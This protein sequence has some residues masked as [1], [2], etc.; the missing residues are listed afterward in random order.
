M[1]NID[2]QEAR[3]YLFGR[4][5]PERQ[6]ELDALRETHA[7]LREEF[8]ALEE[9]LCDQY[10]A[11][12]LP[13]AEKQYF[14]THFLTTASGK[15]KL[16]FAELFEQ[17]RDHL[18]ERPSAVSRAPAPNSPPLPASSPLFATFNRNPAFAV[19]AIVLAGLLATLVGWLY[20]IKSS[21]TN[22]KGATAAEREFKLSPGSVR[23][24]ADIKYLPAPAKDDRVK[25]LLELSQSDFKKYKTQLF[26]E[27]E[28]LESQEEL[29][30]ESRNAQYVVPV[31]V[32]GAMLTP[33]DYKLKLSG[34]PDSGQPTYID[35]YAFRITTEPQTAT[36][37]E[38]QP[39]RRRDQ[40]AR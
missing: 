21:R 6:A 8:L 18:A 25:I 28:A 12:T 3:D 10:L 17:Y 38:L 14:E 1:P 16:R 23:S 37:S 35:V 20:V 36:D 30:T 31:T 9:E 19:S 22:Q 29:H 15:Q 33:G 27:N 26:R 24:E 40:L 2:E 32:A 34:V 13:A 11:G 4:L 7:D 5:S 39:D